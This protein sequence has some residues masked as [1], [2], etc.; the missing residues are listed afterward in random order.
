M[1]ETY[2]YLKQTNQF[3]GFQDLIIGTTALH[4]RL[5]LATLNH[6]HF[7]RIPELELVD[8]TPYQS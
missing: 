6:K 2:N 4:Y 7:S 8:L 1:V 5:P 3:I